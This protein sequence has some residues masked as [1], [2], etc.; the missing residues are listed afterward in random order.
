MEKFIIRGGKKLKGKVT[1]SGAKNVAIKALVAALLTNEKVVIENVPLIL[2]FFSTLNI[3]SKIGGKVSIN[4]HTVSVTLDKI[5]STQIPLDMGA[6]SRASSMFMVPLLVREGI[7]LIPNPGGCRIGARPIDR[8]IDGLKK[9][10]ASV[11]YNSSDGFFHAKAAGLKATTYRF[12]KNTHTG[13]ETLILAAT[14]ASGR[15][16]LENASEE[17]E[18]DDLIALLNLMGSR[19]QRVSER[20]IVIDGVDKLHGA[21]YKIM[22]DRNEAV[23]FAAAGIF[24]GGDVTVE[25][26]DDTV[27]S[28]FLT[29]LSQAGAGWEKVSG[30]M[31]FYTKDKLKKTDVVTGPHPSFMTDWQGP[32]TILMTQAKGVSTIH[33]TVYENRFSYTSELAK[34]GAKIKLYNPHVLHPKQ[35][36][37]FNWED[38]KPEYF[39]GARIIGPTRLHN[40]VLT[41]TDIRAGA[42]LVLA[43]L[44]ARGQ[45]VVFGVE[46]LDRGYEKFDE[47]LKSLGADIQR[48]KV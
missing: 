22:P 2:D 12:E 18:V 5:R 35:F 46:H 33:E 13:T 39:H 17:P 25:G 27:L 47:G 36:Y 9:M 19:I 11:Y 14:I 6:K 20:T 40:A 31:R 43:A 10:G 45:S 15:T 30:G 3:I 8:H 16:V 38:N 1:V 24:T 44:A 41:M 37:N 32:W 42:T 7:A 21:T 4:D 29:K 48:V 28:A 26:A 23:T 34:M